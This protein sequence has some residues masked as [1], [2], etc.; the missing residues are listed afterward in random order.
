M[1][2]IPT[3]NNFN[4]ILKI[5]LKVSKIHTKSNYELPKLPY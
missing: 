3:K 2:K 4:Y 5:L 1:Q